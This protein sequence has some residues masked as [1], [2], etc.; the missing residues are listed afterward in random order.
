M[1]FYVSIDG[2]TDSRT[3]IM[4]HLCV[5]YVSID[6]ET[7]YRTSIMSHLCVF[8]VSIDG[9]TNCKFTCVSF[10]VSTDSENYD[11]SPECLF[12]SQ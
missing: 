4:P 9:E 11:V 2:E 3:S 12:L 10:Y 7:D 5:F 1:F 6:C 8:H